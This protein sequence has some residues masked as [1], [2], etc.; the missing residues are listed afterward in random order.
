MM[1][2]SVSKGQTKQKQKS[3]LNRRPYISRQRVGQTLWDVLQ[4]F[5]PVSLFI[6]EKLYSTVL[7]ESVNATLSNFLESLCTYVLSMFEKMWTIVGLR[8]L[9]GFCI[10]L[11]VYWISFLSK[12]IMCNFWISFEIRFQIWRGC[13]FFSFLKK[14]SS[15]L[16]VGRHKNMHVL[17]RHIHRQKG[18][19]QVLG[20]HLER[21]AV[22]IF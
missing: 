13:F 21:T 19:R 15:R 22:D 3:N 5:S 1:Y 11:Q 12:N 7:L 9:I 20:R 6:F 18:N 16:S 14:A 2:L 10:F 8:R 17:D 4:F